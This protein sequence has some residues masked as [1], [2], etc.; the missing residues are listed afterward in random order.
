MSIAELEQRVNVLE[1]RLAK[2]ES[3]FGR[4]EPHDDDWESTVGMS[5]NRPSFRDIV[6]LGREYHEKENKRSLDANGEKEKSD[7]RWKNPLKP[8]N[9]KGN[10]DVCGS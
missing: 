1:E 3:L 10:V 7:A 9:R 5:A 8:T 2:L 4:F 6:R